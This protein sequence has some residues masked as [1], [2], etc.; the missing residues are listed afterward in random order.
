MTLSNRLQTGPFLTV[1]PQEMTLQETKYVL[2][3]FTKDS[4]FLWLVVAINQNL[5]GMASLCQNKNVIKMTLEG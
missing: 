3:V 1:S 5:Y 2:S 4:C